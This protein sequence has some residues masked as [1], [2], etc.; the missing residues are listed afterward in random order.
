MGL[1]LDHSTS[2]RLNI[3]VV[4]AGIAGLTTATALRQ[5]G[6]DVSVFETSHLL[7]EVG[8]AITIQP[9][10]LI[11]LSRLGFDFEAAKPVPIYSVG[12]FKGDT[13]EEIES[14]R[15][16]GRIPSSV[17]SDGVN[18][19]LKYDTAISFHRVDLHTQLRQLAEKNGVKIHLGVKITKIDLENAEMELSDGT[20]RRGDVLI[21]ADGIHSFVR[22]TALGKIG[23]VESEDVGWN[24]YRWLLDTNVV[25]ED[26][27][28]RALVRNNERATYMLPD[29][30][31][32]TR[33]VWYQ[34]RNGEI[35]NLAFF[36]PGSDGDATHEDYGASADKLPLLKFFKST[37]YDSALITLV[38]KAQ[39]I[40][41]W[42]LRNRAPL[43]TYAYGKTILIGDAA[44]PM[45][46]F[47]AQGG[48]QALEDAGAL[49]SL[50]S[51]LPGKEALEDRMK[52]FDKVRVKRA[53]RQQIVSSV[54]GEEVKDLGERLKHWEEEDT[55][56]GREGER[57]EQKEMGYN[58]FEECEA[59]LRHSD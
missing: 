8:A 1:N 42:R 18:G 31:E 39:T 58:V 51:N 3:L 7:H 41:S 44:H 59:V 40:K 24:I 11:V 21:G 47:N 35:Q 17:T 22:K 16:S 2:T 12:L 48:T 20:S 14:Y 15:P 56:S 49:F 43:N 30:R 5:A 46:P 10:G 57:R 55:V 37:G 53:G 6:H 9:N 50:F 34:C 23:I 19:A 4:G 29:G 32:T 45:L 52:A 38:E 26:P 13:L 28:L 25:M 36:S 27:S 33:L 54:P